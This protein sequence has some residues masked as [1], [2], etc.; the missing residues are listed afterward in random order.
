MPEVRVNGVLLAVQFQNLTI[1]E[2]NRVR[3]E[4]L[5]GYGTINVKDNLDGTWM[6]DIHGFILEAAT[7]AELLRAIADVLEES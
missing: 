5:G 1:G 2:R 3:E 6:A 4:L 7:C